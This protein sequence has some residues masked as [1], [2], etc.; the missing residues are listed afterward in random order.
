MTINFIEAAADTNK[1]FRI[2]REQ[3]LFA[4]NV[5]FTITGVKFGNYRITRDDGKVEDTKYASTSQIILFTTSLGEDLPLNRLLNKRRI[6]Y[7]KDGHA[8]VVESCDFK[9]QLRQHL[10]SLGRRDDAPDMLKGTV[11]EVANHALKFFKDKELICNEVPGLGRDDKNRLVPLL[12]PC[13][14][15]SFKN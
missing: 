3:S 12:A 5:V 8:S 14:Q 7:D 4:S 2:G 13:I 11:E 9:A 1:G 6:I 10:E 15:F